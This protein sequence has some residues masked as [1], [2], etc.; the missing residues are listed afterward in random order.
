[1]STSLQDANSGNAADLIKHSVYLLTLATLLQ[2]E[3][4]SNGLHLHEC[5]A[6]RGIYQ[7]Q[8]TKE[9]NKGNVQRLL[10][11]P[12]LLLARQQWTVLKQLGLDDAEIAHG[13]WYAGSA[14]L[15][16]ATL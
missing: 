9:N 7:P 10:L 3:P 1:M 12:N 4:W 16:A 14:C 8:N 2:C 13:N 11:S 15:N 5:H 6:G